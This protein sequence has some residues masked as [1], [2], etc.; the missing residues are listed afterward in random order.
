MV[1]DSPTACPSKPTGK[2]RIGDE[3]LNVVGHAL[4]IV[5]LDQETG[6]FL[7]HDVRYAC[8]ASRYDREPACTRLEDRVRQPLAVAADRGNGMLDE[9]PGALHLSHYDIVWLLSEKGHVVV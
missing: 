5:F 6:L 8:M 4:H 9:H 2:V 7:D 3:A 1:F